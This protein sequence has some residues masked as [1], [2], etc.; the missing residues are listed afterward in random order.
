MVFEHLGVIQMI[1]QLLEGSHT[2][3]TD[4]K[5]KDSMTI[6]AHPTIITMNAT[7]KN[8]ILKWHPTEYEAFINRCTI[9]YL[10]T[11]LAEIFEKKEIEEL[12]KCG[13]ELIYMLSLFN[14]NNEY[15]NVN[16]L[17]KFQQYIYI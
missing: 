3:T 17:N 2:L 5:Y 1:K 8:D 4:V 16:V 11:P 13:P 7:S 12:S 14:E 6:D 15:E 9:Y 10:G